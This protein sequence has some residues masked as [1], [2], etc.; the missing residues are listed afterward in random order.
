M[1]D[2]VH[3]SFLNRPLDISKAKEWGFVEEDGLLTFHKKMPGGDLL[4]TLII[5]KEGILHDS[6]IDTVTGDLFTLHLVDKAHGNFVGDVKASYE[7]TMVSA[8]FVCPPSLR[9]IRTRKRN[10]RMG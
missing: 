9:N 10:L 7:D 5:D 1:I 8:S 3:D 2:H 6:M 4:L